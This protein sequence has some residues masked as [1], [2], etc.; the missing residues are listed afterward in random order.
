MA[1]RRGRRCWQRLLLLLRPH[2]KLRNVYRNMR[3]IVRQ[4]LRIIKRVRARQYC[5]AHNCCRGTKNRI[6]HMTMLL[7]LDSFRMMMMMMMVHWRRSVLLRLRIWLLH[8]WQR[9][10]CNK[11]M[12]PGTVR[13]ILSSRQ[14]L[15]GIPPQLLQRRHRVLCS[16][17][18]SDVHIV[19]P[20]V[21]VSR[22]R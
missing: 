15:L 10:R 14:F 1:W 21:V 16:E 7:L 6:S 18:S 11:L 3:W 4:C 2:W 5:R 12:I 9:W 8:R 19:R 17:R 13:W 22:C 20:M